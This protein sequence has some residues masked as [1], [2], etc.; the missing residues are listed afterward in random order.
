MRKL[1]IED[2]HWIIQ[3]TPLLKWGHARVVCKTDWFCRFLLE[4]VFQVSKNTSLKR[5][6]WILVNPA[7]ELP[8]NCW[9][10]DTIAISHC[11]IFLFYS[12]IKHRHSPWLPLNRPTSLH[13]DCRYWST[14]ETTGWDILGCS[15]R[16]VCVHT[17]HQVTKI[18]LLYHR[19][20]CGSGYPPCKNDWNWIF[21]ARPLCSGQPQEDL[22][23][24]VATA[25]PYRESL[26]TSIDGVIPEKLKDGHVK[27]RCDPIICRWPVDYS[28]LSVECFHI[29][30]RMSCQT[31]GGYVGYN[32]TGY[33]TVLFYFFFLIAVIS[34][35]QFHCAIC[36]GL[37]FLLE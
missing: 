6:H 33:Y 23:E 15:D 14:G 12:F 9:L 4:N 30:N 17:A 3:S 25:W 28:S 20:N 37:I 26:V 19:Q 10:L 29:C 31:V 36:G 27:W 18:S 2:I 16:D 11:C 35:N 21:V 7:T 13:D 34:L 22:G 32:P 8:F 24:A 1:V 5:R